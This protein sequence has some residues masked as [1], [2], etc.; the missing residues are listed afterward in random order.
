MTQ[1]NTPTHPGKIIFIDGVTQ[2]ITAEKSAAEVPSR[3]RFVETP[4]GRVPVVKIVN[5][6][7]EDKRT[8]RQYGPEG[9]LLKSTV[10]MRKK[11]G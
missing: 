3:I 11:S 7:T 9:Q 4:Q 10:Q 1:S 8:I 6:T 2:E 5:F